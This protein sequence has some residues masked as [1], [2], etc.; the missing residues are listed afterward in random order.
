MKTR[1]VRLY[2]KNNLHTEEFELP[3]IKE[4]ELLVKVMTDSIC[5]S[6]YK[7][8]IQG[9]DHKRVPDD[10]A[11]N[12]VMMGH[13]FAGIIVEVGEK[14]KDQFV[15]GQHFALQPTLNY[16][17]TLWAPG[18]SFPY[19]GGACTYC[20]VPHQ[21]VEMGCILP[22]SGE[23]YFEA[24]LGEPISCI[25]AAYKSNYHTSTKNYDHTM[26]IKE[27]GNVLILGGC[28]PMGLGAISYALAM[29]KGPGSV[30][31]TEINENRLENARMMLSEQEAAERGIELYYVNTAAIEDPVAVLMEI[32]GGHGYDDVFL[33]AP[34]KA[35]AEMGDR[36][37]AYDGC[38]N[39]FAGP[40]D[41]SF[42]AN[43]NLYNCHYGAA[44]LMGASGGRTEDMVE[45]VRLIEDRQVKASVMV[46]HI[47]G[48][49]CYAETVKNL[50][51]IP[52]GKKLIYTQIDMPLTAIEDFEKLGK[53]DEL[54][55][56]LDCSCK[57]HGGL[58]N[59]EAERILLDHYQV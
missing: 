41:A 54:F 37:L 17:G 5:M 44:H 24:S 59:A 28:G 34:V 51:T 27:G 21:A 57:A 35:L 6:T 16:K 20:I 32:T 9:S 29:K 8:V 23:S 10:I 4:D 7:A 38:Y 33:F 53:T 47:G 52:G 19:Y 42:S 49:D 15:T 43:I 58:W 13:E 55:A 45:A 50:P 12:P 22:Y 48:L 30:V 26:G 1:A 39:I 36:L 46:T 18:Y 40:S 2:G 3:Q 25:I 11:E 31:V 14:L 56:Q